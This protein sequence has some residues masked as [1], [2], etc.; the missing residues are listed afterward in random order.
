MKKY[1][2]IALQI[3][4]FS[5]CAQKAAKLQP[6]AGSE[7]PAA[8]PPADASP[9]AAANQPA[10]ASPPTA[11]T[12]DDRKL[13]NAVAEYTEREKH[14]DAFSAPF[15]GIEE[16]LGKFGDYPSK[17]FFERQ[18]AEISAAKEALGGIKIEQLSSGAQIEY[19]IFNED[20]DV[21]SR[22]LEFPSELLDF[23]Q[24]GNRLHSYM[25]E[26]SQALTDFPFDTAKHYEDFIKR[27]EGFPAYVDN[28][29][30]V[31]KRG[32]R[33]K[34]V[35]SCIVAKKV[36]GTYQDALA[37]NVEKNPFYRPIGF[38][39]S[40][41]SHEQ[42]AKIEAAFR[43]MIA[44]RIQPGYQKFDNFFRSEYLPHCRKSFGYG[45]YPKGKDWYR[46]AIRARTNLDMDP[47]QIHKLGLSEVAR[48][49]GEMKKAV[50]Q[51]GGHEDEILYIHKLDHDPKQIYKSAGD[52]FHAFELVKAQVAEKVPN[53][54][55]RIPKT[56]YKIVESSNPEDAAGSYASPTDSMP[57]GRFIVNTK[58]LSSVP[59]YRTNTLSLHET[60]PGHHFQLALQ[61]ELK[62]ELSEYRRK[63]FSS[64][65]FSEG[66]AL[67]AEYLG[68]EMGI[69][70]DPV[71]RLGHL[72]DEM[73]RAVR[74]VVD[75]GIH[76]MNWSQKK[77]IDYMVANIGGD[78][79]DSEIE[80]NR[81]SVWPA[82][83]LS[84]K[85]GQLK[86]LELR[87]KAERELG[88]KFDIKEF[89]KAIIGYGS[90]TL[91]VMESKVN[92]FIASASGAKH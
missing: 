18:R 30:E 53:Y 58:K 87:K 24:M 91:G 26:S 12:D 55:S 21:K 34:I 27:S 60:S 71:Q 62:D 42:K 19:R 82:Q 65:A 33:D 11:A 22:A 38:M 68:N 20:I 80:I 49:H 59:V 50:M 31:L 13:N 2:V 45:A 81:Y 5:S 3:L 72:D 54:F 73:L 14:L 32:L 70:N 6:A 61:F 44:S 41:I 46:L 92:E 40:R 4:V 90:V 66:W 23:H 86:I 63:I 85:L 48:I 47:A 43:E 16:N 9:P 83:A 74:L 77:A 15:F 7:H 37:T 76:S 36:H 25:D 69:L 28:Q 84:Y 17:A 39:P 1:I 79:R 88:S 10:A 56:D 29:I 75:T 89:H 64:D 35:L 57:F 52:M 8:S 78:R 51:S 67:Y